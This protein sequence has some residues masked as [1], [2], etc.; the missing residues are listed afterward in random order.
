MTDSAEVQTAVDELASSLGHS[1]LIEDPR[2][3][4]LWWSA[5]SDVDD[6]RIR[7]ILQRAVSPAAAKVVVRMK[8]A[9]ARGPVR[10]PAFPEADMLPRWCMP[11]RS[12]A[13]LLGYLWVLDPDGTVTDADLPQLVATAERAASVLAQLHGTTEVRERRR[14]ALLERLRAGP[15]SSAAHELIALEGL[16][17]AVTVVVYA[18]RA[19]LGW[20]LREDMSVHV[21]PLPRKAPTGGPPVPLAEL[22][23]AVERAAV[24]AR[25]ARAGAQLS[26]PTWDALGSWHL[27]AA[28]P[29]E[30]A[31]G[32][33]HPGAEILANLPRA[34]LMTT[35]RVVLDHGGD[36]ARAAAELHIHRTT[37][38]YRLE[39]IEALTGVNLKTGRDR[40]DLHMALR[41]AA[42]RS[43]NF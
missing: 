17:P 14:S 34:D 7:T 35:A 5:Q 43:A 18:P 19:A 20:N 30:L 3:Q 21:D 40:D 41:L 27:I 32:D 2:H 15:D 24:T 22:H 25:V 42:Y 6:T 31:I 33:V 1:V 36:V 10:T 29:T 23:L 16:D 8:L 28:A 39:R 11:V 38:Y 37:L 12:G 13:D 26:R 9:S 4:P